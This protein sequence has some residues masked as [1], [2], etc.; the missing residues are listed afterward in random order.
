MNRYTV[1][2]VK[3]FGA[4]LRTLRQTHG[5]TQDTLAARA[6][7][8]RA[9]VANLELENCLPSVDLLVRLAD[10]LGVSTDSLLGRDRADSSV[11]ASWL[12]LIGALTAQLTAEQQPAPALDHVTSVRL[13]YAGGGYQEIA[14]PVAP[15][16]AATETRP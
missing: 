11:L 15:P 16:E 1:G 12:P 8:V 5:C 7:C 14:V 6:G 10:A 2:A 9:Q 3:H 13:T 4:R